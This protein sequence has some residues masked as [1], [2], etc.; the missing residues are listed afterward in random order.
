MAGTHIEI[1][2]PKYFSGTFFAFLCFFPRKQTLEAL[3]KVE[4]LKL[5]TA[6]RAHKE[7][8]FLMILMAYS[9]GLRASEVVAIQRDDIKD[10]HLDTERLKGSLQTRERLLEHENPLLN[11]RFAFFA[12]LEKAKPK[13]RLFPITRRQFGRIVARHAKT[14]GLPKHKR[15]PHMLKHTMGAEIYEKTKDLRLVKAWLGHK[16]ESSS[17]IYAGRFEAARAGAEVQALVKTT[18]L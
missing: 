4:L 11:E 2:V 7:R 1:E 17:L 16:R 10:G 13:K 12:F 15:H 14:A 3:T 5:L 18:T 8:D 6:A 9:H